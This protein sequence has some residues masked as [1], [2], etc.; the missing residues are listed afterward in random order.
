MLEKF[1]DDLISKLQ[2]NQTF[3]IMKIKEII[4]NDITKDNLEEL[5]RIAIDTNSNMDMLKV[6]LKIKDFNKK[7][8]KKNGKSRKNDTYVS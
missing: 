5:Q 6:C 2:V 4:V 3:F 7:K 1:K 8:G